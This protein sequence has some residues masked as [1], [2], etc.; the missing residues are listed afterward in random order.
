MGGRLSSLFLAPVHSKASPDPELLPGA[1]ATFLFLLFKQ[2]HFYLCLL[3]G[4]GK[5]SPGALA[6]QSVFWAVAL[7]WRGKAWVAV[8]SLVWLRHGLEKDLG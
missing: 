4:Q 1:P 2:S 8:K 3:P 6:W 5:G 7:G